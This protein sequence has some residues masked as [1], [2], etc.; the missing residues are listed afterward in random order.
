M[1]LEFEPSL[2]DYFQWVA[3]RTQDGRT[4]TWLDPVTGFLRGGVGYTD[5]CNTQF[6]GRAA[7]GAKIA[8][9]AIFEAVFGVSGDPEDD[10]MEGVR[11]WNFVHDEFLMEGP[12]ATAHL[13]APRVSTLMVRSMRQVI[14]DV[15]VEAPPAL[16]WRWLKGAEPVYVDGRL[17]PWTPKAKKGDEKDPMD[18][19]LLELAG[20]ATATNG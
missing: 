17:V 2:R 13:W 20:G 3:A 1:L 10:V 9:W 11:A 6:Q 16:M 4:F 18:A 8:M 5:G 14:P 12:A 15:R 7:I 19:L